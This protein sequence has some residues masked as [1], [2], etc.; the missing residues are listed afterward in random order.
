MKFEK[1]V[2]SLASSGVI[3]NQPISDLPICIVIADIE[4]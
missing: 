2:K 4:R 3:Y 1:F